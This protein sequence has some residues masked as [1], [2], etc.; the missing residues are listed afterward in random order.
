MNI[1][2]N[3]NV[4]TN[5][6]KDDKLF[7]DNNK[8]LINN[9]DNDFKLVSSY[10]ICNNIVTTL[11]FTLH[12]RSKLIVKDEYL[13]IIETILNNIY[14]NEELSTELN[15]ND[16]F[17][18]HLINIEYILEEQIIKYRFNKCNRFFIR[19]NELFDQ[20]LDLTIHVSREIVKNNKFITIISDYNSEESD[21]EEN[22]EENSEEDVEE[23]NEDNEQDLKE[24]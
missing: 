23:D 8:L 13:N 7:I 22:S 15:N 11:L 18:K 24:D 2:S 9:E 10:E 6:K 5:L 1:E 16:F 14:E 4:L 19:M 21:D 12:I 3:L 20:F 17:S